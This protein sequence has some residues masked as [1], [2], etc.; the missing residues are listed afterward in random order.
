M[1]YTGLSFI[2]PP[3][4]YLSRRYSQDP[5]CL[6]VYSS[7]FNPAWS[8]FITYNRLPNTAFLILIILQD[9]EVPEASERCS[10]YNNTSIILYRP[11]SSLFTLILIGPFIH[12]TNG[13]LCGI[14]HKLIKDHTILACQQLT[15][16][17]RSV[18][19]RSPNMGMRSLQLQESSWLEPCRFQGLRALWSA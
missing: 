18:C 7:L 2:R 13:L 14:V 11:L 6:H 8:S 9:T 17:W 4:V 5:P 1:L 3:M 16:N 12:L 10:A 15:S 19:R